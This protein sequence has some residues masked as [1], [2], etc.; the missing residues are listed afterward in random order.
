MLFDGHAYCFPDVRGVMGF[1]SPE[2]QHVHVQKALSNHHVQPWR[3]RDH[4]PGSTRTLM[5]QSRWPDD[6]C[7]LDLN[8]GPTSHGR[9]EWTVDG[10]RYV[11]QYFPPSIADMSYP[12]ANLIAEMDYTQVSG[13]L[14]HRNPY[15]GL[16]ND[17]IANC[18]RQYPGRLYGLAH[19]P[20]WLIEEDPEGSIAEVESAILRKGLSGLQFISSQLYLYGRTSDWT[21]DGFKI[22]WD[23]VASLDVPVYFS[24]NVNEPKREPRLESYLAELSKLNRWMKRYPSVNCVLTHGFPFLMFSDDSGINLPED[25]WAPFD[26]NHR[27]HL[28]LLF[29]IGLGAKFDYPLPESWPVIEEHV[30]RV[31]AERLIWGTDMPVVMRHWTYQQNIDFI[32]KYCDFLKADQLESIMG[33]TAMRLL[34]IV[35]EASLKRQA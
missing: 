10:E 31:G 35:D 19:V 3:E 20:E 7:V 12:P 13:A 16:G 24:L 9:Y 25:L 1:S 2:A 29:A 6:D 18:V 33:G 22:F 30:S 32:T 8:F 28:Q 17:F 14:L 27:L 4:R 21:S 26:N 23:A 34:G 15:V 11:K 5:D